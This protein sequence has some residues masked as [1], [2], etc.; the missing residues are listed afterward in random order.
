M[1]TQMITNTCATFSLIGSKCKIADLLPQILKYCRHPVADIFLDSKYGALMKT[2]APSLYAWSIKWGYLARMDLPPHDFRSPR[3]TYQIQTDVGFAKR[4]VKCHCRDCID[5]D[6]N[7]YDY[8]L[9][10]EKRKSDSDIRRTKTM[11]KYQENSSEY[12]VRMREYSQLLFEKR[13]DV[14]AV[15]G[16]L[17]NTYFANLVK[18]MTRAGQFPSK[19]RKPRTPDPNWKPVAPYQPQRPDMTDH[20]YVIGGGGFGVHVWHKWAFSQQVHS[21]RAFI[22]NPFVYEDG[23]IQ[24]S[25]GEFEQMALR[26]NSEQTLM[27]FKANHY[28]NTD[29]NNG[30]SHQEYEA[31]E[32]RNHPTIWW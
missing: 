3:D 31:L 14:E 21:H 6:H 24:D 29:P 12:A 9:K 30:E 19:P 27:A 13:L 16:D 10:W 20:H 4:A 18:E 15:R 32:L 11:V 2:G 22:T 7:A 26:G 23:W 28:I 5:I 25:G 1:N 17:S 8:R